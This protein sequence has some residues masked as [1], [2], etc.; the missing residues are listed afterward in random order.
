[1][2][3]LEINGNAARVYEIPKERISLSINDIWNNFVYADFAKLVYF[4]GSIH[5]RS[6]KFITDK[7]VTLFQNR[8]AGA[9]ESKIEQWNPSVSLENE[10][11]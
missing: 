3:F 11:M 8:K 4:W 6:R 9:L 2:D 5:V 7:K 10:A 1:M